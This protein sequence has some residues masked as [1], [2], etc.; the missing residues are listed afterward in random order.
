MSLIKILICIINLIGFGMYIKFRDINETISDIGI[1]I[2][3]IGVIIL[4]FM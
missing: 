2:E 3:T 4:I 1:L